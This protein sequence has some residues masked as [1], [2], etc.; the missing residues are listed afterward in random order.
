VFIL[1][2][3]HLQKRFFPERRVPNGFPWPEF[4]KMMKH[5]I[6]LKKHEQHLEARLAVLD[7]EES[8]LIA[9]Q[10]VSTQILIEKQ[11]QMACSLVSTH[12]T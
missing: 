8:D 3:F 6:A 4:Q 5:L 2:L 1:Y 11:A 7:V 12:V 10:V 9:L